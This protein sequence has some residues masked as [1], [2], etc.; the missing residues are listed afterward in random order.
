MHPLSL[1][2]SEYKAIYKF[3]K[4]IK[5]NKKIVILNKIEPL[6]EVPAKVNNSLGI[7][8]WLSLLSKI[9]VAL[10]KSIRLQ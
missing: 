1:D 10:L 6:L 9:K 3:D 5:S 8:T 2:D 7:L 4:C